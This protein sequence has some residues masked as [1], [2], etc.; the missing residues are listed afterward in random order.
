M[1]VIRN[2]L[3]D[4]W[5]KWIGCVKAKN[6][7]KLWYYTR[8]FDVKRLLHYIFLQI[9]LW[10]FSTW[11]LMIDIWLLLWYVFLQ[12]SSERTSLVRWDVWLVCG[13]KAKESKLFYQI[14]PFYVWMR[15]VFILFWFCFFYE[16]LDR[17]RPF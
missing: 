14:V 4:L 1:L 16:G 12:V 15:G 10:M 7:N 17:M 11:Y 6:S 9:S 8:N 5:T 13:L 2:S 3:R